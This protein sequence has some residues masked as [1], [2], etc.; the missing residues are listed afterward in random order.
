MA[1]TQLDKLGGS[2]TLL[3]SA[4]EG[5]GIAIGNTLAPMLRTLAE[6]LTNAVSAFSDLPTTYYFVVE[7]GASCS[8]QAA[9]PDLT[10]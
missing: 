9:L 3:K 6:W 4:L 8:R 5:A 2:V 1:D 7:V 10:S